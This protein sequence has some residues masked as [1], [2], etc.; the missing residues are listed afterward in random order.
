MSEQPQSFKKGDR[1]KCL[2][3]RGIILR[4]GEWYTAVTDEVEGI[5]S[6]R[7]VITIEDNEGKKYTCHSSRFKEFN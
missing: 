5:F 6:D 2:S 1:L 7:P 3:A 4:E